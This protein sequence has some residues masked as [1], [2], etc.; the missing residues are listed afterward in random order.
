MAFTHKKFVVRTKLIWIGPVE[1]RTEFTNRQFAIE[2]C[3]SCAAAAGHLPFANALVFNVHESNRAGLAEDLRS[4]AGPALDHG[5]A[6]HVIADS[7]A[8]QL[9]IAHVV[10]SLSLTGHV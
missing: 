9:H 10:K 1:D 3:S 7:D 2:V 6:I 5:L 8:T 4:L